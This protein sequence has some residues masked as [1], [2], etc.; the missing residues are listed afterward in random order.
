MVFEMR[1][2]RSQV[3][4]A[5]SLQAPILLDGGGKLN[6]DT[7]D[8][9]NEFVE[10]WSGYELSETAQYFSHFNDICRL[11]GHESPSD[12]PNSTEFNFQVATPVNIDGKGYADVVKSEHFVFEYKQPGGSLD[13]AYAQA[14]KYRDSLGNP[15]LTIVSDFSEIRVHTNFTGT[16]SEVYYITLED[17][18]AV[19]NKARHRSALGQ[20]RWGPLS[21]YEVL[22][23]CFRFP[24]NLKPQETPEQLT[25]Q[26]AAVFQR[27]AATLQEWNPGKDVEIAKF[28][29]QMLFCMFASDMHLLAKDEI[30]NLTRDLGNTPADLFPRRV[31]KLIDDMAEGND[32]SSPRIP[33]FNGGLFDGADIDIHL[34]NVIVDALAEA[35][36][37]DWSQIE[38]SIFGT[39]FE[40]VFNPD[41]R[42]QFGRHYTSR[43]DIKTLI[44]PVIMKPLRAEWYHLKDTYS[45]ERLSRS[46]EREAAQALQR[47]VDRV[48]SVE[49]LDPACGSGNFLYVALNELHQLE[50]EVMAWA[51]Q[52][53]FD[54]P[55]A[56][57]HPRQLYGIELDEYA[58]QLASV[59]VWIGHIQNGMRSGVDVT[60]RD[61]ILEMLDNIT[62]DNAILSGEES[63]PIPEWPE[64]DFIVGNPP[65]LGSR[66]LRRELDSGEVRRI[67][68]AWS[69]R[70]PNGADFCMYWFEQARDMIEKGRA[71]RA[72]LLGT[73]GIRGEASRPVLDRILETGGIFFAVSDQE[74]QPEGAAVRISMVGF[75]DGSDTLYELD[76]RRVSVINS[77]LTAREADVTRARQL[78]ENQGIA[79]Q[80][81]ITNN[82]NFVIQ[83]ELAEKWLEVGVTFGKRL[84]DVVKPYVN[85][86]DFTVRDSHRWIIDFGDVMS[87]NEAMDYH[88]PYEYLREVMDKKSTSQP[89]W[90]RY[91]RPRPEMR[92]ALRG[93]TRYI[94]T[95]RVG[96]HRIFDW[97]EG[98]TLPDNALV[99]FASEDDLLLGLLQ[100][101]VHSVWTL[102]TCSHLSN[103]PRYTHRTCFGTF[104]LPNAPPETEERVR[105][106]ARRLVHWRNEWKKMRRSEIQP[107]ETNASGLARLYR[108]M[109]PR[110]CDMHADLD[111]AVFEAYGWDESPATLPEDLLLERLLNLN[112]KRNET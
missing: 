41:K 26:A 97:I 45:G 79:F 107:G 44:E 112:L 5:N 95:P 76:G 25:E 89:D 111:Q 103:V 59:V 4:S 58:H 6:G 34:G 27:I 10:K 2:K 52:H 92:A 78:R 104:P 37:L 101:R 22:Q 86:W 65:F 23:A 61:P 49:I 29:S 94:A 69:G 67:H 72:G 9:A 66:N 108:E 91:L 64:V 12:T 24:E 43:E 38:P 50:R 96:N 68:Q 81:V 46:R 63:T 33:K 73:Q 74:W 85:A 19:G 20:E 7:Q 35:D 39:L 18:R 84:D 53:G 100:S 30:T 71:K 48:A 82:P 14:L 90:W 3:Q 15:P 11:I 109:P 17:L 55:N 110:L 16:V 62:C 60:Q 8:R 99:V 31:A 83:S 54:R 36:A 40:R 21:V 105:E 57:V 98:L 75:D 56:K 32:L 13:V 1:R 93:L 70:V 47:F 87:H 77:D 80:G 106:A 88:Y 42:S 28:L 102:A 51:F